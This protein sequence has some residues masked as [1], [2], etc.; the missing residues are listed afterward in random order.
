MHEV[1]IA[2]PAL[3]LAIA[4]GGCVGASRIYRLR[5]RVGAPSGVVSEA[6][7]IVDGAGI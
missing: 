2:R 7:E 1:G 3:V 4:E 6:L 5:L